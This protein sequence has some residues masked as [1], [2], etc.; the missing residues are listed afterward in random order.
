MT[1]LRSGAVDK[2]AGI[3]TQRIWQP[4]IC[5][6][7]EL[8]WEINIKLRGGQAKIWG[9]IAHPGPPLES[10][11]S[12]KQVFIIHLIIRSLSKNMSKIY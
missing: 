10:P 7:N 9:A 8:K 1:Q 6:P 5:H 4:C 3:F 2:M 12:S 11:L